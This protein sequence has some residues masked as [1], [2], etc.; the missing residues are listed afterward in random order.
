MNP[1]FQKD[2]LHHRYKHDVYREANSKSCRFCQ[3]NG[4]RGES[5]ICTCRYLPSTVTFLYVRYKR[6]RSICS[7]ICGRSDANPFNI[8]LLISP[9]KVDYANTPI[10]CVARAR[11]YPVRFVRPGQADLFPGNEEGKGA[12]VTGEDEKWRDRSTTWED[13]PA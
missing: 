9:G 6:P 3:I 11:T 10:C 12:V 2:S 1:I 13:S 4:S 5:R 7:G 8:C